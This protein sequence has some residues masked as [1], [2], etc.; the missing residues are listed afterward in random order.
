MKKRR[1]EFNVCLTEEDREILTK[2][3]DNGVNIS[4]IFKAYIREYLKA[5]EKIKKPNVNINL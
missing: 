3:I 5:I 4:K 2:L 1:I